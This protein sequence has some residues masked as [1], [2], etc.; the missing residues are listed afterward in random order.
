MKS[1]CPICGI[2]CRI[3]ALVRDNRVVR[4]DSPDLTGK[5][6][7]LCHKVRFA[8]WQNE[9]ERVRLALVRDGRGK[10]QPQPLP[11]AMNMVANRLAELKRRYGSN[12]IAGIASSQCSNDSLQAFRDL[13]RETI[14]SELIDT[15][16]GDVYRII[17]KGMRDGPAKLGVDV[18]DAL[19]EEILESDCIVLVMADPVET[20]PVAGAY[21]ARA[22]RHSKA[23]LIVVNPWQCSFPYH[24]TV[25]LKPRENKEVLALK[26]LAKA[27]ID[28]GVSKGSARTKAIAAWLRDI[29]AT[30]TSREA[31]IDSDELD[32]AVGL[33]SIAR[34]SLIIF[35]GE[36]LERGDPALMTCLVNLAAVASSRSRAKP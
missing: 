10:L 26:A 17:L 33:L 6:G 24:A 7:I 1:V 25:W 23:G 11:Q 19:L 9:N 35:E 34:R 29:D 18:K 13:I 28:T 2:G 8:V 22:V 4:I 36:V 31:G 5:R 21:I 20:H 27:L 3:E 32:R 14:G 16:D 12:C 30:H 15:L